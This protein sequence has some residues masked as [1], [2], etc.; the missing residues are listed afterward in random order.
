M[1]YKIHETIKWNLGYVFLP[2]L[3]LCNLIID[4]PFHFP[5]LTWLGLLTVFVPLMLTTVGDIM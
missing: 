5:D 3:N 2:P 1:T 4:K